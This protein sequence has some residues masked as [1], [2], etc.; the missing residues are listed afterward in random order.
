MEHVTSSDGTR[1]AYERH[2][3]GPPII[4][5]GGAMADHNGG[6]AVAEALA[7]DFTVLTI[8]RRARG[9][10]EDNSP[11]IDGAVEREVADLAALIEAVGGRATLLGSS[12]GAVLSLAAAAHGL[13]VDRL[14]VF[15]PPF[16][17]EE[18][19]PVAPPDMPDQLATLL[20]EGRDSDVAELF[21][22]RAVGL[23]AE[24]V[25]QMKDSPAWPGMTA[26]AP[27]TIYD[28]VLTQTYPRPEAFADLRVPTLV[29]NGEGTWPLLKAS[30]AAL[31]EV[32]PNGEHRTIGGGDHGFDVPSGAAAVREFMRVA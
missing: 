5:V 24:M 1:I 28:A 25:A 26:F 4:V 16:A 11:G 20:A 21:L 13:P 31:A 19:P 22:T 14:A 6:T 2:G 12:S 8:D 29:L 18:F 15:E 10:S 7:D 3:E 27:S 17:T 9:E 32:L 23:P 30:A